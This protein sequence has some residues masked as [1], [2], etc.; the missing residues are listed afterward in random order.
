MCVVCVRESLL[1]TNTYKF[2]HH[3]NKQRPLTSTPQAI[4]ILSNWYWHW[5][6]Q[7]FPWAFFAA[8]N[9]LQPAPVDAAT[10]PEQVNKS[11]RHVIITVKVYRP[12]IP[13]LGHVKSGP[14][15]SSKV[16]RAREN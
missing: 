3:H 7:P 12:S 2:S 11:A 14:S 1:T 4:S 10:R 6:F 13:H 15:I 8:N 9:L 5:N 16:H